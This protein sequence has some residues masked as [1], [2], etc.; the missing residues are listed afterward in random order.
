MAYSKNNALVVRSD[1]EPPRAPA[2]GAASRDAL[3][4]VS[5]DGARLVFSPAKGGGNVLVSLDGAGAPR[6]F[7][8]A[9]KQTERKMF[10]PD[11]MM[12]AW[13]ADNTIW[14]LDLRDPQ[15]K[16]RTL[17]RNLAPGGELQ[18]FTADSQAVVVRNDDTVSWIGLD[19]KT[20]RSLKDTSFNDEAFSSEDRCIPSPVDANVL[21]ISLATRGTAAYHQWA[22]DVSGALFLVDLASGTNYRLTPIRLAAGQP[23][24]S[25]DGKRLYFSALPDAP[26]NGPH[27]LYRMNAD[28]TGLTD[29]G[30]GFAPSVG[31]R[32]ETKSARPE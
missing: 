32:P 18:G 21:V 5:P 4:A 11:G 28:G 17:L 24:W 15:A 25:P 30:P 19:G 1:Q 9:H 29:L 8:E 26:P 27:H 6:R 7:G 13:R 23:A 12:L 10:S 16:P 31:T 3:P 2:L 22:N 14:V 20:R